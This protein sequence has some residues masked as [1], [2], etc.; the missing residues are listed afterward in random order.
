MMGY[1]ITF[2]AG[3]W[4]GVGLMCLMCIAKKGDSQ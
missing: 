2:I 3:A 4:C 1:I